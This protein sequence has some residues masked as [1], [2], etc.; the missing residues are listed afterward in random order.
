MNDYQGCRR[1]R[2]AIV[3]GT[4]F[5]TSLSYAQTGPPKSEIGSKENPYYMRSE[6]LTL[7][8][9]FDARFIALEE[10]LNAKIHAQDK[11]VELAKTSMERRLDGMNE[12]RATLKDQTATF[13]T[14][15]ELLAAI[16]FLAALMFG[17]LQYT[18][19]SK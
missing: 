19:R 8:G 9:Y 2:I 3:I 6:E 15:S 13:V 12:F 18:K 4:L 5:I 17:L 7:K 14:R 10:L 11:A 16:G 1:F